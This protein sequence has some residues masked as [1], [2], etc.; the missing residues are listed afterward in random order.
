MATIAIALVFQDHYDVFGK[1]ERREL[2]IKRIPAAS[3]GWGL[4][5]IEIRPEIEAQGVEV[6]LQQAIEAEMTNM[7]IS[8]LPQFICRIT[9]EGKEVL[10][11]HARFIGRPQ[12]DF[13]N[14]SESAVFPDWSPYA[15]TDLAK[16]VIEKLPPRRN[17]PKRRKSD[18]QVVAY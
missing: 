11:Y 16:K 4:P 6:S 14:P 7:H 10:I 13:G 18:V 12:R 2:M 5:G 3:G 15:L 9:H 1:H 17:K 8:E